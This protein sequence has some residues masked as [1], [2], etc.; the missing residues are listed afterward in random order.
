MLNPFAMRLN[1]F[2][3]RAKIERCFYSGTDKP[4]RPEDFQRSHHLCGGQAQ[5]QRGDDDAD[6]EA[7]VFQ[8]H[9]IHS[10]RQQ[11]D[12]K[13]ALGEAQAHQFQRHPRGYAV[14]FAPGDRALTL[15]AENGGSIRV[16]FGPL[17]HHSMQQMAIGKN[18]FIIVEGKLRH[19]HGF[20]R[21]CS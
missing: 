16:D 11:G 8:Q 6:F 17:R 18:F 12:Q 19:I 21:F 13:I 1:G 7:A 2:P 14:E 5:I 3:K 10:E 20:T 4:A 15:R 9:V